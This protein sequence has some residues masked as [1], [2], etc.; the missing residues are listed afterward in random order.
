MSLKGSILVLVGVLA[1]SA[2]A[3]AATYELPLTALLGVNE[4][5]EPGMP[6]ATAAAPY[7]LGTAFS[8]ITDVR[9]RLSGSW[10]PGRWYVYLVDGWVP[11]P[12]F[13]PG[14]GSPFA[15]FCSIG[16]D[17]LAESIFPAASINLPTS[18]TGLEQSLYAG[19]SASE[20]D[21]MKAGWGSIKLHWWNDDI[22]LAIYGTI[23]TESPTA[24][25]TEATLIVEGQ[26]VPEPACM[27]L[28]GLGAVGLLRR[29]SRA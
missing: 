26:A 2:A 11:E 5:G 17:P 25:F 14:F 4:G 20:L 15:E 3:S 27:A 13:P 12:P 6:G 19:L 16:V 29:R 21:Q 7:D 24:T 23:I 1:F 8:E 9:L 18:F 28:L 22:I 10:T